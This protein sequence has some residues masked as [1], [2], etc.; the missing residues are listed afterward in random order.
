MEVVMKKTAMQICSMAGLVIVLAVVSAQAQFGTTYKAHIPFDFTVDK[1]NMQAG[2]YVIGS[3][4]PSSRQNV[5]TIRN[6][7]SGKAIIVL[8]IPKDTD[9]RL[10]VATLV[11]KHYDNQYFL[12]EMNTPTLGAKFYK[13]KA[14][15][16]LARQQDLK[17]KTVALMK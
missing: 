17:Q 2:D 13:S 15:T 14:E 11:F 4:I 6:A 9:P 7:K 12:A 8:V 1:L 5:L 16:S 3:T 10:D